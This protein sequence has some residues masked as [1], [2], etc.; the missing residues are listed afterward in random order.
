MIFPLHFIFTVDVNSRCGTNKLITSLN[1]IRIAESLYH[2]LV[3]GV[4]KE[5]FRGS[6][7][8]HIV[9]VVFASLPPMASLQEA[10]N[11]DKLFTFIYFA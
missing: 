4:R 8:T 1:N 6:G 7:V 5:F 3:N 9:T 10:L 2:Q 11:N